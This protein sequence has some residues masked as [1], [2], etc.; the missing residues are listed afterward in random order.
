MLNGWGQRGYTWQGSRSSSELR[1]GRRDQHRLPLHWFGN[2]TVTQ[3]VSV[4]ASDFALLHR[5]P[6][7][8]RPGGGGQQ[9]YGNFDGTVDSDRS[10]T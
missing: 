5:R 1:P 4:A 7:T 10:A 6:R 2:F 9:I 8:H 3:N